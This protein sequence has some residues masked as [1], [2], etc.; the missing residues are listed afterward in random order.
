[1]AFGEFEWA[2]KLQKDDIKYHVGRHFKDISNSRFI[3]S[4][5]ILTHL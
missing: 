2:I 4:V 1:M 3:G 5:Q